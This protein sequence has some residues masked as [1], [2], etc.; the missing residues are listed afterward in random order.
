MK[1]WTCSAQKLK[2]CTKHVSSFSVKSGLS[3]LKTIKNSKQNNLRRS[4]SPTVIDVT[5]GIFIYSHEFRTNLY[6][7]SLKNKHIC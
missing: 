4:R 5:L 6:T 2:T 3:K 1:Y 7:G